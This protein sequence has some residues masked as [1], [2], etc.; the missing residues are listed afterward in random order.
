MCVSAS[1][2]SSVA[3]GDGDIIVAMTPAGPGRPGLPLSPSAFALSRNHRRP[4][5]VLGGGAEADHVGAEGGPG[6]AGG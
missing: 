6:Q 4:A 2:L 3:V 5:G 1:S